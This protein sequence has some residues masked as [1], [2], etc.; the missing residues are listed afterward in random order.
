[1]DTV[2]K[3][4]HGLIVRVIGCPEQNMVALQMKDLTIGTAPKA[5]KHVFGAKMASKYVQRKSL[6]PVIILSSTL[7][8]LGGTYEF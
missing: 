3:T 4:G 8:N 7:Y 5:R 6:E 1:M 2:L